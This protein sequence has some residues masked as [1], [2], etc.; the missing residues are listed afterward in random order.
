MAK[1]HK[2]LY[3]KV[4]VV[5][6]IASNGFGVFVEDKVEKQIDKPCKVGDI[7]VRTKNSG[8]FA[9]T[10]IVPQAEWD[11]LPKNE[12]ELNASG[13]LGFKEGD[14]TGEKLKKMGESLTALGVQNETLKKENGELRAEVEA[15]KAG[16]KGEGK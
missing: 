1:G 6:K 15:I 2:E 10:F 8:R 3:E 13:K 5:T 11:A 12:K 7:V 16:L 9:K 14:D 4:G